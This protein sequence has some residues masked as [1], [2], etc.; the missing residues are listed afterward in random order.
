M[1]LV[2]T[3]S[4][5][6]IA[7]ADAEEGADGIFN[8]REQIFLKP[9]HVLWRWPSTFFN[10]EEGDNHF[11]TIRRSLHHSDMGIKTLPLYARGWVVQERFLASR[12]LH[13]AEDR[14][15]WECRGLSLVEES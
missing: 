13:F 6:N 11:W 4:L 3:N 2:Y 15:M 8:E 12:V 9:C 7:A 1:R 5:V 14:I 10:Y